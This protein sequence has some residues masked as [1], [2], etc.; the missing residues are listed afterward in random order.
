MQDCPSNHLSSNNALLHPLLTY[1]QN[2]AQYVT[3]L[4]V[5]L[6][7]VV[8]LALEVLQV[9]PR[10]SPVV[11]HHLTVLE[12]LLVVV[13][14]EI[15]VFHQLFWITSCKL[16]GLSFRLIFRFII[17]LRFCKRFASFLSFFF[18]VFFYVLLFNFLWKCFFY[19]LICFSNYCYIFLFIIWTCSRLILSTISAIRLTILNLRDA[20]CNMEPS[21]DAFSVLGKQ[22]LDRLGWA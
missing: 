11:L 13:E 1:L 3:N 6:V 2:M 4:K 22:S 5:I 14:V 19:L 7:L 20:L 16:L 12:V 9:V 10:V 8:L 21:S 17:G 18:W 15:V